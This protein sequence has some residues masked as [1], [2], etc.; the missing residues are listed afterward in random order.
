MS[1]LD[2]NRRNITKSVTA[3]KSRKAVDTAEDSRSA[4]TS[5][6][7]RLRLKMIRDRC[8]VSMTCSTMNQHCI[9][10]LH[11]TVPH[12]TMM[13]VSLLASF[14]HVTVPHGS[15]AFSHLVTST[16]ALKV[17]KDGIRTVLK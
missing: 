14:R 5:A 6:K 8:G 2:R 13:V 9:I 17:V 4:N 16:M 11:V 1:L 10:N 7:S 12:G 3:Q 15:V